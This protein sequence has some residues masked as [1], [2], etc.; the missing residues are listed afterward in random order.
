MARLS[1]ANR[2][3]W[4]RYRALV[5]RKG[6][7]AVCTFREITEGVAHCRQQPERQGNCKID[8]AL[9]AFRLDDKVLEGLRDED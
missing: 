8:A 5:F 7:C 6:I 3:M 2:L 1:L 9:P 4:A